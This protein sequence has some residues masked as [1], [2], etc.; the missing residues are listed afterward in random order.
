MNSICLFCIFQAEQRSGNEDES[1]LEC[2]DSIRNASNEV[3]L[4]IGTWASSTFETTPSTSNND[5]TSENVTFMDKTSQ[6]VFKDNVKENSNDNSISKGLNLISKQLNKRGIDGQ[7]EEIILAS[8]RKNTKK[9]Y[10]SYLK[11]FSNYCDKHKLDPFKADLKTVLDFLTSMFNE[12]LG[13]NSLNS[14]RSALS[15][16]LTIDN[17]PAGSHPVVVRY[18]KGILEMRPPVPRYCETWDVNL[19]LEYFTKLGENED[20]SLSMLTK[21]VASLLLILSGQRVQTAHLLRL[22]QFQF[23]ENKC[24]IRITGSNADEKLKHFNKRKNVQLLEFDKFSN[25]RLCIVKCL[26]DYVNRTSDHRTNDQ[27]LLCHKKPYQ[28]ASKDTVSRWLKEV[29]KSAGIDTNIFLAHSVRSASTSKACKL[30]VPIETILNSAGWSNAHTFQKFY[31]RDI[32]GEEAKGTTSSSFCNTILKY[33]KE[34][35]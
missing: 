31:F 32:V 4:N 25:T 21:K 24:I 34:K 17:K 28:P 29:M 8:W 10:N 14:A 27:F 13:Y 33:F 9:Q 16:I 26:K 35:N 20:L 1:N 7:N 18:M 22:R 12:G 15:T 2:L 3:L 6:Y 23:H 11:K 30:D 5:K 19:V